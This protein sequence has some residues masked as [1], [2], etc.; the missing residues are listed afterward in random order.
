METILIADSGSTKTD[1]RLVRGTEQI[2]TILTQGINPYH[3]SYDDIVQ[4]LKKELFPVMQSPLVRMVYFYGT[5]C[6]TAEKKQK[7]AAALKQ[8]FGSELK[9]EVQHDMLAAARALCGREA[10]IAC[11]IGTGSNSCVYDGQDIAVNGMGLGYLLGD[12]GAGCKLGLRLLQDY[13]YQDMPADLRA[14]FEQSYDVSREVVL[15]RLYQKTFPNRY[16]AS[17]TP[18]LSKHL[19]SEYA[20]A[21]LQ[22]EMT[23]FFKK[24]VLK[25][26]NFEQLP[27]HFT[28]SVAYHFA[29]PLRKTAADLPYNLQIGNILATPMAGLLAYHGITNS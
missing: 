20:Q 28:G 17:F 24:C 6:S 21:L 26:D 18:F 13:F 1:W 27:I 3:Q 12:E 2:Q 19:H 16:S 15:E 23:I 9:V 10:G 4:L 7:I 14:D 8:V 22:E 5:G 29:E 11:I 25:F